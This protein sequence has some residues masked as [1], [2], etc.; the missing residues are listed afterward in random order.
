M[1]TKLDRILHYHKETRHS[2]N[3]FARSPGYLDWESQPDPFR[4][5]DGASLIE[6]DHIPPDEG[7]SYDDAFTGGSIRPLP[8]NRHNLSRLFYD[9]LALS[10]WKEAGP[11]RW[12]LRVNPSSGNLHP[13]EGYLIC[14]PVDGL[15]EIP[16]V[17]H[18]APREH[19]LEV[20]AEFPSATW[21]DMSASLP[22][23]AILVGL[24]S[25]HWREAWKYGERAYRYC[26]LDVGHAIAALAV[27]ASGMG[28]RATLLDGLGSEQLA[29]LLGIADPQGAEPEHP[30]C[31]LAIYPGSEELSYYALPD[32]IT[33]TFTTLSW[34]GSPNQLSSDHREWEIIDNV[35]EA[36]RK[37]PTEGS[38]ERSPRQAVEIAACQ[39]TLPLRKILHQRRSAQAMDGRTAITK[40][41]FFRILQRCLEGAAQTPFTTLPWQPSVHMAIFVHRVT[42]LE[43]GLYCLVRDTGQEEL[44]RAEM[45]PKFLWERVGGAPPDM[46]LYHLAAGDLRVL[47]RDLSCNQDIASDGCFSLAMIANFEEP[48][49]RIGHWF[50][51]RLYWEC[52]MIGQTLY[53][54]AE[55]AALRGTGIGCFFDDP[56]HDLLGLQTARFRS[57]YHFTVG[58]PVEDSRLTT[59][60]PYPAK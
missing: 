5:Y 49:K 56:V 15:C 39:G 24:T 51:P 3:A 22:K 14:G 20:R 42:G 52:G 55:A 16:L 26:Q 54:E 37:P 53:L 35:A 33:D 44:L 59:L 29:D 28:W 9:S 23:E 41:G 50:Y 4:R 40:D 12:A 43:P 10:A 30:D 31:L 60:P 18:N 1:I 45:N 11:T 57:L 48:L 19:A 46:R 21:G 38:Y 58:K 6:L 2:F 25:I 47:S 34:S 8:L 36:A 27:A 7:P 17:C 13:T 32:A